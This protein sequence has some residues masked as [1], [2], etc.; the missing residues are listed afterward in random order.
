MKALAD[1][2]ILLWGWRRAAVA[3]L[4]GALSAL[5]FPPFDFF[6]VLWLTMPVFV[7]LLDG[8]I[9]EGGRFSAY[10]PAFAV[11]WSFG[12]GYF[13]AGMWWV[14]SA[15]LVEA[16]T[17]GILLPFAVVLLPAGLALFWGLAALA[18][19][20]MWPGNWFRI[21]SLALALA[22]AEWLRGH[23]FTG[24]PWNLF[25]YVFAATLPT[26]QLAALIG[27]YAL[28]IPAVIIFAAPATFWD[29]G[30]GRRR[31]GLGLIAAI[32]LAAIFGY[33]AV[34]LQTPPPEDVA[35]VSLRIVQ[36]SIDQR[37]K[38][39]PENRKAVFERYLTLSQS[40]PSPDRIGLLTVSHLI[41]PESAFPFV[42]TETPEALAAIAEMLPAET[43]LITGALRT[44]PAPATGGRRPA[45]NSIYVLNDEG[46]IIAAYDKTRLVPFG[47]F[48][49]FQSILESIGLEQLTR[50]RGGFTAGVRRQ[51]LSTPGT[52]SFQP[53]ICYEIIFPGKV[54]GEGD[55]PVW[56]L[57]VSNDAWFGD[58]PGPYQHLRQAQ[59]RAVEEG[60]PV[61]RAANTG[62]SAIIDSYGRPLAQLGLGEPGVIDG[63][64]P[65]ALSPPPAARYGSMVFWILSAIVFAT[66][67]FGAFITN[68][69]I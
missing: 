17:F 63:A 24:F 37:A 15:F 44:E 31:Y 64:L 53:L 59:L 45:F 51:P 22:V 38:W 1:R 7:W 62:I 47:E 40:Q 50:L 55:R 60:L 13:L 14:G 9:D 11:G 20:F 32:L 36:P 21:L 42:L 25:G 56:L 8:A 27:S 54:L 52:P 3:A 34:R 5:A 28:T 67:S 23:L 58:S 30:N 16:E 43:T 69:P 33:G 10:R 41:W 29:G 68:K 35:G 26:M 46:E 18:A 6:P 48:L 4:A 66:T 39:R 12:F 19:R 65:G 57:N 2:L 61:I 49:P